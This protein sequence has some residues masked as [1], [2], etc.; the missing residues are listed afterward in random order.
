MESMVDK[1]LA[2]WYE[3]DPREQM[4][5][6]V[7]GAIAVILL[8]VVFIVMPIMDWH[9]RE[10]KRLEQTKADVVEVKI[11]AARVIAS[12]NNT[13]NTTR[14]QS[15]ADLINK[16]LSKNDLVMRGFQP[17]NKQD[18][19]LRLENAAFPALMQWLYELEYQHKVKIEELTLTPAAI[20]GQL[21]VNIRVAE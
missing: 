1:F 8:F 21:M 12:R 2:W 20:S 13:S 17:G 11:L 19:R 4:I 10:A 6:A 7:G 5:I 14:Q 9:A 3:H 16:S 18:A 15:L